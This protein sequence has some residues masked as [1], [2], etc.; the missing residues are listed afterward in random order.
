[1]SL[2]TSFPFTPSQRLPD[3]RF[4]LLD[5]RGRELGIPYDWYWWLAEAAP[6][7]LNN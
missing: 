4:E 5:E 6:E 7:Q 3:E 2:G 1:M